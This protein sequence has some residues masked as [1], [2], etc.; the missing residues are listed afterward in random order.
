MVSMGE[1]EIYHLWRACV[2]CGDFLTHAV[3]NII[4]L[5]LDI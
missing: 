3:L 2:E 4:A 1:C 5:P